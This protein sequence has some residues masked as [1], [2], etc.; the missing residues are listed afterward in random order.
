MLAT[1]DLKIYQTSMKESKQLVNIFVE[2]I[3]LYCAVKLKK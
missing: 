1:Q 3:I 2:E